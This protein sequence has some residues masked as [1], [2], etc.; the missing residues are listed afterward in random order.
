MLLLLGIL[1]RGHFWQQQHADSGTWRSVHYY[2][3]PRAAREAR[4]GNSTS[5]KGSMDY[6]APRTWHSQTSQDLAVARILAN[7]RGGFFV[8]LAANHPTFISNTRALERDLGWSGIC[9]DGN[10]RLVAALAQRR[11]CT[12]VSAVVSGEAD[13]SLTFRNVLS[14]S[15]ETGMSGVVSGATTGGTPWLAR[16]GELFGLRRQSGPPTETVTRTTVTLDQIL[17]QHGAP[18][19]IDY[20]SLDVRRVR[21]NSAAS[22][23]LTAHR[24]SIRC[25]CRS[26]ATSGPSSA[27]SRS[28]GGSFAC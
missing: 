28:P 5:L 2:V 21:S 3:G 24:P 18:R 13:E 4:E 19:V 10:E 1:A 9:I 14:N 23:P 12:V 7:Q 17:S 20:L 16:L 26:R 22:H 8:D 11:R 27:P 15:W 6:D 25:C